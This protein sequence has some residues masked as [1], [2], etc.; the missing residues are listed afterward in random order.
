M[1]ARPRLT[2]VALLSW[3]GVVAVYAFVGR[4]LRSVAA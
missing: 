3:G 1:T 4:S 2:F